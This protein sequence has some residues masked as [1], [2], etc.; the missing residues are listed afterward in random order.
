[1]NNEL[2]KQDNLPECIKNSFDIVAA[3]YEESSFL[4]NDLATE[5]KNLRF[6]NLAKKNVIS[7]GTSTSI[8]WPNWWFPRYVT[9]FFKAEADSNRILLATVNYFGPNTEDAVKPFLIVGIGEMSDDTQSKWWMPHAFFNNEEKFIY[10]GLD[11]NI[12]DDIVSPEQEWQKQED[13][14]G[15]KVPNT[16]RYYPTAGKLFAVPLIEINTREDIKELADRGS[17]LWY[18]KLTW[19]TD[20]Q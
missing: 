18:T 20:D 4:L 15:F 5:L 14:W 10:Y 19:D 11:D 1:M 8:D 9:L 3:V 13:E 16:P 6:N 7:T 2:N 17:K 12:R